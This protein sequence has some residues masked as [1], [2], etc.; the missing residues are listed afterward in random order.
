MDQQL[1]DL[2]KEVER[3]K[4]LALEDSTKRSYDTHRRS[5]LSFCSL[6]GFS[7]AHQ[8][9]HLSKRLGASSVSK[10][11]NIIRIMHLE[12]GIPDPQVSQIYEVKLVMSG[13][14]KEMGLE[15]SRRKPIT[16]EVLLLLRDKLNFNDLD[17]ATFWAACLVGFFG[18]L[19]G[20][21][22]FHLPYHGLI[23]RSTWCVRLSSRVIMGC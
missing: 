12:L 21:I 10:Y 19:L 13:L 11:L 17:D 22:Y 23:P 8:I 18:L 5:Y 16:P 4:N 9:S 3:L 20:P 1:A 6:Y 15:P 7:P 14:S 2:V